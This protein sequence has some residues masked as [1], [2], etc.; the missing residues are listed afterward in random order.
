M[1]FFPFLKSIAAISGSAFHYNTNN[2]ALCEE[3]EPV[4]LVRQKRTQKSASTVVL[5]TIDTDFY[6]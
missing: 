3:Q 6:K 2:I 5:E 4:N 1:P